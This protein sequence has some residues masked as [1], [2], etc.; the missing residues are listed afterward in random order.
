[1][2]SGAHLQLNSAAPP[3]QIV[4]TASVSASERREFWRSGGALLFGPLQLEQR[5]RETFDAN[6]SY[7]RFGDLIFCR[8]AARVSHRAIRSNAAALGDDRPFLKAVLQTRG[9]S[10]IAQNGRTTPLLPGEWTVYDAGDPYSVTLTAGGEFSLIMM[11]REKIVTRGFD[12]RSLVLRPL[13]ARRGLGKLIWGLVDNTIDQIPD[14]QPH[15]SADVAEIV[16]QMF[17]LALFDSLDGRAPLSSSEALRHRVKLYISAHL[18]DPEFSLGKL[19]ELT[20]CSKRY[21]HMIF[22][23]EGVS[24]SDYILKSRLERCRTDLLDPAIAHRSITEIAYSWGFNNSN[25]FS[26]CFKRKF[27]MAPRSLRND[28]RVWPRFGAMAAKPS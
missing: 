23:A 22:R 19:A 11:P 9:R 3:L 24:I 28:L 5:G 17:R 12:L 4:S 10:V 16:A 14:L 25:H 15:S 13:S 2:H 1:M 7:T 8:L 6:L 27:G 20:H 26:R 21:L 18:K